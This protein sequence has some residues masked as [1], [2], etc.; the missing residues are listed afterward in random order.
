VITGDGAFAVTA[1]RFSDY[2]TQ[3]ARK[4]YRELTKVVAVLDLE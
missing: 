2:P 1:N 4:L 3:I